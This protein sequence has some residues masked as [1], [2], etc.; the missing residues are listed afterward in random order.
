VLFGIFAGTAGLLVVPGLILVIANAIWVGLLFGTVCARFRDIP[1]IVES[2]M[3]LAF[4]V[5]PVIWMPDQLGGR[6]YLALF[7]PFSYFVELIR[8]PLLGEV[9]SALTWGLA[10]AVTAGGWVLAA[11]VFVRF[12]ARVAY[13]L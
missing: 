9:P 13:W 7:N 5:T 11:L 10:L 12:R 4:F 8:A 2:V 1:Q 6:A 3:R